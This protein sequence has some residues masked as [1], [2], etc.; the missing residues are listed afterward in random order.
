MG[1]GG[2]IENPSQ[3]QAK[4]YRRESGYALM[5]RDSIHLQGSTLK[6]PKNIMAGA[7]AKCTVPDIAGVRGC[8]MGC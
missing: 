5:E 4:G 8:I 6:F 3:S 7:K 1:C 2:P